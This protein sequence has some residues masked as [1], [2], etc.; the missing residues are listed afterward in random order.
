ML[1]FSVSGSTSSIVA[2]IICPIAFGMGIVFFSEGI[3]ILKLKKKCTEAV[4]AVIR[5][6]DIIWETK[7]TRAKATYA[8]EYKEKPY[9]C[10]NGIMHNLTND[11]HQEGDEVEILVNPDNPLNLYDFL[12]K[13]RMHYCLILGSSLMLMSVALIIGLLVLAG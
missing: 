9:V 8:Y 5:S 3:T 7:N 13:K 10:S 1:F 12:A 4:T 6:F 11:I 2:I